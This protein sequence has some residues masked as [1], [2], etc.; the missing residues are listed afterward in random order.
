M[1]PGT[2]Q[3]L[4]VIAVAAVLAPLLAELVRRWQ[5]PGVL[6]ELVLGMVIGPHLLDLAEVDSFV[7]G[8]SVLGLSMLFFLAGYDLDPAAI[9]GEPLRR[10]VRGWFM[11]LA[12][13]LAVGGVLAADGVVI[14][15][16]LVGLALTTTA[17]GTLMPMIHD[18]GLA[19]SPF[20]P[21]L[22]AA[23]AVGEF[24]PIVAVT[25]L[26]S[27]D[28]P[29]HET[30]LLVAFVVVALVAAA[31]AGRQHPPAWILVM[32]RNLTTSAQLP[33]RIAL[34]LVTVMVALAAS[35]GLDILL[36]AFSA[37]LIA[38]VALRQH[39]TA[40]ITSR[41]EAVGFGFLVP[42]FFIVSGMDFDVTSLGDLDVALRTAAFFGLLLAVRGVPAFISHRRAL[43]ARQRTALFVL[44]AT[45]LP[46]IVVITEIGT[47]TGRMHADDATAL[48]AAGML[49][50]LVFPLV[51]FR[52]LGAG[53]APTTPRPE[54]D[55][56]D[57]SA[58]RG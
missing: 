24:G 12:L 34:L 50:V 30:L 15:G 42:I 57:P 56:V 19:H 16:L 41:L 46:L 7:D 2:A 23:G 40:L 6:F 13:G 33:V 32:H 3:S 38:R 35:L 45:A 4:V 25:V 31:L 28:S 21:F 8:L 58:D 39:D 52:L 22:I 27:S 9:R 10:A 36:G 54:E 1:G 47:E 5:V 11:T 18:R 51:G 55:A 44:Q 53:V 29:L 43:A 37:G 48:V 26:L 49:S 17:L 20:G 14:G